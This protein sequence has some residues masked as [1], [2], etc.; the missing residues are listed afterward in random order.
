M[1]NLPLADFPPSCSQEFMMTIVVVWVVLPGMERICGC[2]GVYGTEKCDM[3]F[4]EFK[5]FSKFTF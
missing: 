4:L 3:L 5:Y 1:L 2:L